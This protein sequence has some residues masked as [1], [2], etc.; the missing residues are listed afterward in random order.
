MTL[1]FTLNKYRELC[2]TIAH[3]DYTLL[4]L[5][6]YFSLKKLPE[7]F[8]ILRHDV[9]DEP[10]YALKM[11][12][13]ENELGVRSTYYFRTIENVFKKDIILKI[14][15]MGH[16]VG[17]HY[18]VL[19][20]ACGNYTEAIELFK[21]CLE[22][23][24]DICEI[25]TIAQHGSPLLGNLN[26]TSVSGM[27]EIIKS[28]ARGNKV[29]TNWVNVDIWKEYDFR[30]FGIIGE[31]YISIDFNSLFYISDTGMSW[32]NKYRMK[33]VVKGQVVDINSKYGV[34]NTDSIIDIIEGSRIDHIYLLIHA[35]QWRDNMKDWLKWS[36]MK[37]VRND[38][39]RCLKFFVKNN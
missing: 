14:R 33:D 10:E 34:K 13:L 19:D 25:K 2:G 29:F 18:E 35:D 38:G 4:T 31:A 5:E 15:D 16:E 21:Q 1:D 30:D 6:E 27:Y 37:H 24:N 11:A 28:L 26:A 7:K 36:M 22:K 23:F 39:K 20:E 12:K 9:D 17:Y 32:N 8:I 3:S